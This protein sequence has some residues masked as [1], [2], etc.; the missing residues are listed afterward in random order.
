[1]VGW[2]FIAVVVVLMV[3]GAI[4]W[5]RDPRLK[6]GQHPTFLNRRMPGRRHPR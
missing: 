2:A 4:R 6:P 5:W 3:L 1:V